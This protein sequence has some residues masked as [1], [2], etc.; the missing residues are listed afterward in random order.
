MPAQNNDLRLVSDEL[1]PEVL[2]QDHEDLQPMD[3]ATQ[4]PV[5]PEVQFNVDGRILD[6]NELLKELHHV[7]LSALYVAVRRGKI[8]RS[9]KEAMKGTFTQW[10]ESYTPFSPQYA[11]TH[12]KLVERLD[13]SREFRRLVEAN[14]ESFAM[15]KAR[16][17]LRLT[18]DELQGL[19][20]QGEMGDRP[21]NNLF[22]MKRDDL[23]DLVRKTEAARDQEAKGRNQ[24]T[25]ALSDARER[26]AELE[27][28]IR[29]LAGKRELSDADRDARE[30][31]KALE[32][33]FRAFADKLLSF[34]ES[35]VQ[36]DH[37]WN[38]LD[39]MTHSDIERLFTGIHLHTRTFGDAFN[40][41]FHEE[42][43]R[44]AYFGEIKGSQAH[45]GE[46]LNWDIP[47]PHTGTQ[48]FEMARER[49]LREQGDRAD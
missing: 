8:L 15:S 21:S 42:A 34:F 32:E 43:G 28:K 22:A 4:F 46:E 11:R 29:D 26:I 38:S 9:A 6:H 12:I 18:D 7:Q 25:D 47:D 17:M 35:N 36:V 49:A 40:F 23:V 39:G 2:Q 16:E 37:V 27:E 31:C 48:V 13:D 10:L 45:A 5:G 3:A 1:V 41:T 24:A 19:R 14:S 44:T 33:E 20:D 30:Q